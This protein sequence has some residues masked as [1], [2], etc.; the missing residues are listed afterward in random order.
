MK[1]I[2]E[3]LPQ[4]YCARI[5][6]PD[7]PLQYLNSYIIKSS[8]RSLIID[9]GMNREECLEAMTEA[10]HQLDIDLNRTDFFITHLHADHIGLVGTLAGKAAKV[11][12]NRI[13]VLEINTPN[14][15]WDRLN[16]FSG[17]YGFPKVELEKLFDAHPAAK[18]QLKSIPE[19][20]IL[21]DDDILEVGD[22]VFRCI[23]TPG[24]SAGH[25][26]LYEAKN[27]LLVSGDHIL[28]DITPNIT[29]RF[30]AGKNALGEYLL[31]L[32]KVYPLDVELVLPGHRNLLTDM[33]KRIRD[34]KQH[35]EA[36][37][38]EQ[39]RILEKGNQ[40]AYQVTGQM[41]WDMEY[42]DWETLPAFQKYFAFAEAVSH[43]QY[44]E[45]LG[46][47]REKKLPDGK[48]VYSLV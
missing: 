38:I 18:Y 43:L 46:K 45:S 9:T 5:P 8:P 22:Y 10:L 29:T 12:F 25:L 16:K 28:G 24:H 44:L 39:L 34:L 27:K 14:L 19:F 3:I 41:T 4:F 33:K 2:K 6:L 20:T 1:L 32:D 26:C 23:E 30:E 15:W 13:E 47:V 21:K 7:S 36:R 42:T 35:H 31:S 48:I 17:T 37:A 11:Y 40:D